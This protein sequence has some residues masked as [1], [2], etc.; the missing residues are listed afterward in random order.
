LGKHEGSIGGPKCR[1]TQEQGQVRT[2]DGRFPPG[3][4][5]NPLGGRS[6]KH[7]IAAAVEE[8][9]AEFGGTGHLT[10]FERGLIVQCARIFT[11]SYQGR[12]PVRD[13]RVAYNTMA[14]LRKNVAGARPARR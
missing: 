5:G 12:D 9:S 13:L 2:Q 1:L 6:R 10:A 8:L 4:S 3:V 14:R 11:A 7:R